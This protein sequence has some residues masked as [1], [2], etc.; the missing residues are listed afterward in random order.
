MTSA[1]QL[2]FLGFSSVLLL[3]VVSALDYFA[4]RP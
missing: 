3:V 4:R 1:A 2:A